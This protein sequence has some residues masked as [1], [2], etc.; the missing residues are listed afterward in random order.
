[1][2][3]TQ[4]VIFNVLVMLGLVAAWILFVRFA[5]SFVRINNAQTELIELQIAKEGGGSF[6]Q[7]IKCADYC[8]GKDE[9]STK[10]LIQ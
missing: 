2:K 5:E 9:Y 10:L 1:M 3:N 7:E 6:P 8:I 4:H